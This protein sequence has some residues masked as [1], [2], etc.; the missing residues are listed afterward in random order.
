MWVGLVVSIGW[1][2]LGGPFGIHP[3]FL[4]FPLSIATYLVIHVIDRRR[5]AEFAGLPPEETRL[6][7]D[8]ERTD[9]GPEAT[10]AA[11]AGRASEDAA[12]TA[13]DTD[14]GRR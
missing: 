7:L 14:P 3:V 11:R 6:V 13:A 2:L 5:L 9:G 12:P 4:G 1:T 8:S 10:G